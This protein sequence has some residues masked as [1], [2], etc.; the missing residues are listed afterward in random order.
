ME[1]PAHG[2]PFYMVLLFL[3]RETLL[4]FGQILESL[5]ALYCLKVVCCP[6][7]IWTPRSLT[8]S[9][10]I[11]EEVLPL[12]PLNT[13]ATAAKELIMN[14]YTPTPKIDQTLIPLV[15]EPPDNG[16][17]KLNVDG[18]RRFGA[19]TIRAG[20]V[21]RDSRGGWLGGVTHHNIDDALD[22]PAK[23]QIQNQGN[24]KTETTR[25]HKCRSPNREFPGESGQPNLDAGPITNPKK[26]KEAQGRT[27]KRTEK[28]DELIPT[29]P[30]AG[31]QERKTTRR[32]LAVQGGRRRLNVEK[33]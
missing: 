20:G 31:V 27:L 11:A 6:L 22:S 18:S 29:E 5:M 15:W 7:I 4:I 12:R 8:L 24:D 10:M 14:A 16:W 3:A 30:T 21:I 28:R 33:P 9:K 17:F 1:A 13:I 2:E 19:G 32:A 25:G 26:Q 23:T